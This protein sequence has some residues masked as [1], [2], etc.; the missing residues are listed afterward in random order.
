ME[1]PDPWHRYAPE[2]WQRLAKAIRRLNSMRRRK[3]LSLL[4]PCQP[5]LTPRLRPIEVKYGTPI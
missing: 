3:G 4:D 2:D 1:F 5:M